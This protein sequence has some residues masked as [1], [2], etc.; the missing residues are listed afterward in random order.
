MVRK[1]LVVV[2]LVGVLSL[3]AV[4][5]LAWGG[6][7]VRHRVFVVRPV[8]VAPV[9]VEKLEG[10][11]QKVVPD[12]KPAYAEIVDSAGKTVKV[13]L[14]PARVVEQHK[15]KLTAGKHL[16]ITGV[17]RPAGFV[18][19]KIKLDDETI[20]L[21]PRRRGVWPGAAWA[22]RAGFRAGWAAHH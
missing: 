2:L 19:F 21:F 10:D 1:C 18:A 5:A 20:R 22:W 4:P 6:P 17:R 8:P 16:T 12:Q 7:P 9:K 3:V 15:E 14:G 11:I 13:Y